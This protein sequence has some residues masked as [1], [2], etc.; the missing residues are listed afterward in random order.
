MFG[1]P[2]KP[3]KL[4]EAR[5]RVFFPFTTVQG[6]AALQDRNREEQTRARRWSLSKQ[7]S[8]LFAWIVKE[9]RSQSEQVPCWPNRKQCAILLALRNANL[10]GCMRGCACRSRL[11]PLQD[12][13]LA[14]QHLRG[15]LSMQR[16]GG[17]LIH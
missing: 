15:Q 4:K 6:S 3:R 1:F 12:R 17:P 14:V 2:M 9:S 8:A 16:F 10:V 5:L 11:L 7:G 13:L